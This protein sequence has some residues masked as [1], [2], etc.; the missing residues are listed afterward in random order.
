MMQEKKK[1]SLIAKIGVGFVI[2]LVL[3]FIIG[4]MATG[5]PFIA[6]IVIPVLQLIGGIFLA[7]LKML[8]VPLVF[9]SLITI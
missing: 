3:G 2:G 8:I 5:S 9:S 1:M 4:P 6:D 7:L